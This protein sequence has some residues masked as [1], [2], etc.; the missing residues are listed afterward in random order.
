MMY[1]FTGESSSILACCCKRYDTGSGIYHAQRYSLGSRSGM[2]EVSYISIFFSPNS[3][4]LA[5]VGLSVY[6]CIVSTSAYEIIE[7]P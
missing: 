5:S 6:H 7:Q 2:P 4:L 3:G 1:T